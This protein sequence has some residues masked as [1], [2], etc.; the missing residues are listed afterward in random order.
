MKKLHLVDKQ[1]GGDGVALQ[2]LP[3]GSGVALDAVGA[4]DNQGPLLSPQLRRTGV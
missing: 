1:E 2:Q 3:Q 4:A